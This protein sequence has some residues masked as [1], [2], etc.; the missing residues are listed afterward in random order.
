MLLFH[1]QNLGASPSFP[2]RLDVRCNRFRFLRSFFVLCCFTVRARCWKPRRLRVY[3][4][5]S[6][7]GKLYVTIA[8]CLLSQSRTVLSLSLI[9][10][11]APEYKLKAMNPVIDVRI[12]VRKACV[13][14]RWLSINN[15][16][17]ANDVPSPGCSDV[18]ET[19]PFEYVQ[20][21]SHLRKN[22]FTFGVNCIDM[23][24]CGILS[25]CSCWQLSTML[26]YQVL[27]LCL[28]VL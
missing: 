28:C 18:C 5:T 22:F 24:S 20:I 26:P 21:S 4:K 11:K 14:W 16:V 8:L 19:Q 27:A 9:V 1:L 6:T 15:G 23:G 2:P 25:K 10:R 7:K 17:K 12:G 13:S 3:A